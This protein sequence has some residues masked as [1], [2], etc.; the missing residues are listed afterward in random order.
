MGDAGAGGPGGTG[1]PGP[2][3][4]EEPDA[5]A[6]LGGLGGDF[7]GGGGGTVPKTGAGGGGGGGY[8]GGGGGSGGTLLG[9]SGGGGEG[10]GG[11]AAF[12]QG[13]AGGQFA[14]G[15]AYNGG[16]GQNGQLGNGQADG[17]LG[18]TTEMGAGG[19]GGGIS[20]AAA[21]DLP[22]ATTFQPGSGGGGGSGNYSSPGG[23]GGGGGGALRL[24]GLSIVVQGT[25][26]ILAN[27]G[28]GAPS[29][30]SCNQTGP[31][32][33]GGGGSG[34]VD[35]HGRAGHQRRE[36][37]HNLGGGRRRGGQRGRLVGRRRGGPRQASLLAR[38]RPVFARGVV[39]AAAARR[40]I[41]RQLARLHVHRRVPQLNA[42]RAGAKSARR[43]AMPVVAAAPPAP[44][45]ARVYR[46]SA[47]LAAVVVLASLAVTLVAVCIRVRVRPLD[48]VEGAVL[49]EA[50]RIRQGLSLYVDP[51]VGARDYGAIP[52]RYYVLYPPLYSALL[53]RFPAGSAASIGRWLSVLAFYG[54][55]AVV[56][57]NAR[58]RCRGQAVVAVAFVGGMY[59]LAEFG[60][61]AR[62]D[63]LALL[64][65]TLAAERAV[66]RGG[67]DALA[68]ALFALAAWTKPNVVGMAAGLF[69]VGLVLR[70]PGVLR[71]LAACLG[72]SALVALA[73]QASSN[74]A[75]FDHL[76]RATGQPMRAIV[77]AAQI[78]HRAQFFCGLFLL[79]AFAAARARRRGGPD[80]R[81]RRDARPRR[82]RGQRRL[83][84]RD[85]LQESGA[86]P[87]TGSS[88][89]SRRQSSSRRPRPC[90]RC[91]GWARSSSCR[92]CG[93]T[94]RA[95][96]RSST[97]C[98]ATPPTASS[99]RERERR[100][101]HATTSSWSPTSRA[102][103]SS[104]TG[105]S[106]RTRSPSRTRRRAASFPSPLGS[107]ISPVRRWR[108]SSR[109]TTTSSGPCR[110]PTPTTTLRV[111]GPR[112]AQP[113]LRE[114]RAELGLAVYARRPTS[115]P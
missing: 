113:P 29:L 15:A 49:F 34:S 64:L 48:G 24:S 26:K 50:S 45:F 9:G 104:S 40:I 60:A 107:T 20:S 112:R 63:A 109:R 27:G 97:A 56:A 99:S 33:G 17:S 82:A 81:L 115:L 77:L 93:P 73:L 53:S 111:A 42:P 35:V 21:M 41:A 12:W 11:G 65:A 39:R 4:A 6:S 19:G 1:S 80:E 72:V 25:A 52:S 84:P 89:A 67:L 69:A 23:G 8:A 79:A 70:R 75:W 54:G 13:G 44:P 46:A 108:A 95:C 7:G 47:A 32:G 98:A 78:N 101:A 105:A 28:A 92:P 102:S 74:G 30:P 22:V 36:R 61:S 14:N 57:W 18:G 10:G 5:S 68:G 3:G 94:W 43:A 66:R 37:S 87:T 71:G 106:S 91:R 16:N 59:E 38:D 83:V 90:S 55:L 114:G 62:P 110:R 58:P 86:R 88:R 100:A 96:A 85:E 76:T 51:S 31:G 2:A 103:R